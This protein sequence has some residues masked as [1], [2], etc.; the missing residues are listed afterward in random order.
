MGDVENDNQQSVIYSIPDLSRLMKGDPIF[1]PRANEE[2]KED[3][4]INA[5]QVS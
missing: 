5:S 2:V 3:T 4:N 1:E